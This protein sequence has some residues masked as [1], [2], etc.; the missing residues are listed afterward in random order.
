MTVVCGAENKTSLWKL[1][2]KKLP[3]RTNWR[4]K[5]WLLFFIKRHWV[6]LSVPL[7]QCTQVFRGSPLHTGAGPPWWVCSG[8]LGSCPSSSGGGWPRATWAGI[9]DSHYCTVGAS[10]HPLTHFLSNLG[11]FSSIC[12]WDMAHYPPRVLLVSCLSQGDGQWC[13]PWAAYTEPP[14]QQNPGIWAAFTTRER[15]RAPSPFPFT[16]RMQLE[17]NKLE[18]NMLPKVWGWGMP[19][20]SWRGSCMSLWQ[21]MQLPW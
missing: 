2:W 19:S 16:S 7:P 20:T 8:F 10:Q 15:A 6:C 14:V 12:H 1:L 17:P 4:T 13:R 11:W 18:I 5:R 3:Q 21:W 9:W